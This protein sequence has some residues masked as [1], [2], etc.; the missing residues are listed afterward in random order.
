MWVRDN[1]FLITEKIR[2]GNSKMFVNCENGKYYHGHKGCCFDFDTRSV[3]FQTKPH[4]RWR[5]GSGRNK[6]MV[7]Q[8]GCRKDLYNWMRDELRSVD[9]I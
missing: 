4:N 2:V 9:N 1:T 6:S 5:M 3:W 7:R 8:K